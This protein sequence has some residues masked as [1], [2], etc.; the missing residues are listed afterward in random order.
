MPPFAIADCQGAEQ[1]RCGPTTPARRPDVQAVLEEARALLVGAGLWDPAVEP[2]TVAL[3][4]Q[5]G[6]GI[7]ALT[8]LEAS[9]AGGAPSGD[10]MSQRT[11]VYFGEASA[12]VDLDVVLHEL[13]HVW[14]RAPGV[15]DEARWQVVDG[16]ACH[17][18]AV[19]HEGLSDFVAA[20]LTRDP[21]IGERSGAPG[22]LRVQA[23]CPDGLTGQVHL[24]SLVVSSA[25]WELSGRGEVSTS[26]E[27]LAAVS[28][29]AR[30]AGGD[31]DTLVGAL[32]RDLAASSP[33]LASRF[34]RIV[35]TRGLERCSAPIDVSERVSS[36]GGYFVAAGTQRHPGAESMT[37]PLAF[38]VDVAGLELVT[39][40]LRSSTPQDAVWLE[41]RV[42]GPKAESGRSPLEGT[43][44]L[45]A[46]IPIAQGAARLTFAVATRSTADIAYDDVIVSLTRREPTPEAP[47][48]PPPAPGQFAVVQPQPEPSG[49][50]SLGL[51]GVGSL[52]SVALI[53]LVLR[54]WRH[55]RI[56][57]RS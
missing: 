20:A 47:S 32:R 18:S 8:V 44:R 14:M 53:G 28:R 7:R 45:R 17:R 6:D 43:P 23:G 31:V 27:V 39:V 54:H 38:R 1:S 4:A 21:V 9:A 19:V 34:E 26:A 10:G 29:V 41:W 49:C 22:S 25:L 33:T 48:P 51:E 50:V 16:V 2:V 46:E 40:T 15:H 42:N 36:R 24:D 37:G 12:A 30:S 56:V 5:L 35:S 52:T 3:G 13:T 11:V 55:K 57:Q